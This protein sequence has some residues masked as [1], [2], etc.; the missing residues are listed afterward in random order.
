MDLETE[1]ASRGE[2]YSSHS[3]VQAALMA[4]PVHGSREC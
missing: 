2:S 4:A 3:M 1:H